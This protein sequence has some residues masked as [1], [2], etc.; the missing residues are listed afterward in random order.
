MDRIDGFSAMRRARW[1]ALLGV[2]LA[3][4]L[5]HPIARAEP[6]RVSF[7]DLAQQVHYATVKRGNVTE[8]ISTTREALEAIQKKQPIPDGTQFVL[9]DY[10]DGAIFRYFVM[11]KGAGWGADF[12][13]RRRTGDWQFQWFWPNRQINLKE[14]T[15]RCMACHQSQKEQ[16]YLFTA[17]RLAA[18]RGTPIE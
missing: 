15:A 7:P 10:R 5:L 17:P 18:F 14:N 6:N 3:G 2:S 9:A 11:E 8:H 4:A 12:E 1:A 16:N 13:E